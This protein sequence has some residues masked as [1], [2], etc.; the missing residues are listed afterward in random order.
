TGFPGRV[1]QVVPGIGAVE[2]LVAEREVGDDVAFDGCFE[3]RPLKPGWIAQVAARDAQPVESKPHQDVAAKPLSQPQS[4]AAADLKRDR[5][6]PGRQPGKYLLDE[7][8]ALF[9]FAD[10]YPDARI[11][12]A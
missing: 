6:R 8:Q 1:L 10:A 2:R 12:V 4:F 7:A 3:Q 9:D 5:D 11:H